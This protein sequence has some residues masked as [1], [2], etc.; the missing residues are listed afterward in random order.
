MGGSVG[1]SSAT[2][3]GAAVL[4]PGARRASTPG[5][6]SHPAVQPSAEET[7]NETNRTRGPARPGRGSR[8]RRGAAARRP[9]AGRSAGGPAREPS[10]VHPGTH[11]ELRLTDAQVVRLAAL[12]RRG[13]ERRQATRAA[14]AQRRAEA[15]P[16]AGQPAGAGPGAQ[17]MEQAREQARAELRDAIAGLTSEQQATA[18]ETVARPRGPGGAPRGAACGGGPVDRRW[19]RTGP[20][21]PAAPPGELTSTGG[22]I[23]SRGT[24]RGCRSPFGEGRRLFRRP[25]AVLSCRTPFHRAPRGPSAD[26]PITPAFSDE[27]LPPPRSP[28]GL[29]AR[30][31]CGVRPP[32]RALRLRRAGTHPAR[33]PQRRRAGALPAAAGAGVRGAHA[34]APAASHAGAASPSTPSSAAA[35]GTPAAAAPGEPAEGGA[36]PSP[37]PTCSTRGWTRAASSRCTATTW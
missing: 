22:A 1:A 25:P 17:A 15:A 11:G 3:R 30:P 37:S 5:R 24:V 35:S 13:E 21:T 18:W 9:R 27:P 16:R 12:A 32:P 6:R 2:R 33:L 4:T 7:E 36:R 8:G 28:G 26:P 14:M 20:T 10:G 29:R 34:Q 19:G 23:G 31:R